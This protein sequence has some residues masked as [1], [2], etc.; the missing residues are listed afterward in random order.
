MSERTYEKFNKELHKAY[1]DNL[2]DYQNFKEK[3][4]N[5]LSKAYFHRKI[6]NDEYQKLMGI[7][8]SMCE[9]ISMEVLEE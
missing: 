5:L 3:A 6:S 8:C 2:T 4:D 9:Y 7:Y 1:N